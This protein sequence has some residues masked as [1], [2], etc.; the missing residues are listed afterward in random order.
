MTALFFFGTL[1]YVPVLE[2]VLGRAAAELDIRADALPDHRVHAAAEGP[3]PMIVAAPGAAAAGIVV[4]GLSD[5]DIARLEYY[6]AGYDFDLV[7]HVTRDGTQVQVFF[8]QGTAWTPDGAWDL[9]AWVAR[10]G[11]M[12]EHAA[13]E[14]MGVYGRVPAA[15]IARW[16]PRIRARAWSKVLAQRGRHG[17]GTFQG[18]VEVEAHAQ[19]YAGFFAVDEFTFRHE[20]F[21]ATMSEPLARS[22]FLVSDAAFVLPYD[23]ARDR[24]LLTEQVRTGPIIRGDRHLWQ[25]EGIAGLI[26]PGETPEEAVHREAMEEAGITLDQLEPVGECYASSG[27]STDF[28]HMYVGLCDLPDG[29]TGVGGAPGEGENIR[30][31]LMPFDDL[32]AMAEDRRCGNLVLAHLTYWL[33]FHR[34]RLRRAG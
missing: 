14:V 4:A 2:I 32:V 24:V 5:A 7:P 20:R 19:A 22:V 27:S 12:T 1:Q 13:R 18:R 6:E 9:E 3:F 25:F 17:E 21:D 10:W 15:Q 16:Y 30:S 28:F 23:P 11:E 34:N 33:A 8:P 29:I 31:L 26:D